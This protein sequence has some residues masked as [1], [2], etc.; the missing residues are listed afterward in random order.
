LTRDS[1]RR[2]IALAVAL[3]TAFASCSPVSEEAQVAR[4]SQVLLRPGPERRRIAAARALGRRGGPAAIAILAEAARHTESVVAQYAMDELMYLGATDSATVGAL[5]E[6]VENGIDDSDRHHAALV[7]GR[8]HVSGIEQQ[9]GDLFRRETMEIA[10]DGIAGALAEIGTHE[11][12]STLSACLDSPPTPRHVTSIARA[13]SFYPTE[14]PSLV[15]ALR[16]QL[17]QAADPHV[18][19]AAALAIAEIHSESAFSA[20]ADT[21][22]ND[23]SSM[24]RSGAISRIG[25]ADSSGQLRVLLDVLTSDTDPLC[26][27][28]AAVELGRIGGVAAV[29]ALLQSLKED[30]SDYVRYTAARS[31]QSTTGCE[32]GVPAT[33]SMYF[34]VAPVEKCAEKYVVDAGVSGDAMLGE[35]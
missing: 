26:R 4:L 6:V 33:Y 16:R 20:L 13:L 11:A 7:L 17:R 1:T 21:I 10:L 31:I 23:A 25:N 32:L 8:L 12:T 27:R 15:D 28:N 19:L 35:E 14:D 5:L 34:D 3:A 22:R 24:V 18:R 30:E 29:R 9:L 2:H